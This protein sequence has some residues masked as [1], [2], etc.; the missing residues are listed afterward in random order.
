MHEQP[1][2]ADDTNAPPLGHGAP[3]MDVLSSEPQPPPGSRRTWMAAAG[4]GLALAVVAAGATYAASFLSGGG[5]QPEEMVP[6]SAVMFAKLDLDPSAGQKVAA[7]RFLRN[8]PSL[9]DHI[10]DDLRRSM[11]EAL[12]EEVDALEGVDYEADVEP[13]LGERAGFA[14]MPGER[15]GGEPAVL[16]VVQVSDEAAARDGLR[17][18]LDRGADGGQPPGLVVRDGY[19]LIAQDQAT[20]DR[21]SAAANAA[22]LAGRADFASD[23][24]SLGDARVA[25]A[26]GDLEALNGL[27]RQAA[28]GAGG[29]EGELGAGPGSLAGV[30]GAPDPFG[31]GGRFVY[32]L[33]FTAGYAEVSGRLVDSPA[34][35]G[36]AGSPTG[37]SI[38]DLPA[39]TAAAMG[40]AGGGQQIGE[41]WD[42]Q[43]EALEN[44]TPG[45][46][47]EDLLGPLTEEGFRLPEDLVTLF[48]EDLVVAVDSASLAEGEM[49]VGARLRTDPEALADLFTRVQ[50]ALIRHGEDTPL[51]H[52][53]TPDGGVVATSPVYLDALEQGG[54]LGEDPAFR[55]AL[56]DAANADSALWIDVMAVFSAM[57]GT[58]SDSKDIEPIDG[59][60]MTASVEDGS[61]DFRLRVVVDP[62]D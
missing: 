37:S 58:D 57:G 27:A 45:A 6:V 26:W 14:V 30:A 61:L 31:L 7:A 24:D 21:L 9:R 15:P 29:A 11:F 17:N 22:N 62:D 59:V 40:V 41:A 51:Y 34:L 20:T 54:D 52:R 38:G 33:G 2:P 5:T 13:W 48:G 46:T 36:Y 16:A 1:G 55:T 44:A 39:D 35:E 56:P 28:G 4:A 49:R 43:R 10:T 19:A 42:E 25:L 3:A 50:A 23:V 53:R 8:F 60:G 32:G 12:L 47:L 18:L